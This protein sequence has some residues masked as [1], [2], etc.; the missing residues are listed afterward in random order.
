MVSL[1]LV[2]MGIPAPPALLLAYLHG[3]LPDSKSRV[4]IKAGRTEET[5]VG[6]LHMFW[7]L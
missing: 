2:K 5:Y 7:S 6:L 1:K 4:L 3:V